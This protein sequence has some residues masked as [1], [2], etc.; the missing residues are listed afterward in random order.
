[1]LNFLPRWFQR[2]KP[3][4]RAPIRDRFPVG[5]GTYGEPAVLQWGVHAALRI[6]SFCS[7]ARNVTII[8]D[9]DHR[10]DWVTTYPFMNFRPSAKGIEGH[11]RLKGEVVIE[12][13]V[14]IGYGATI[15]S[16][17]HIGNGAVVGACSVVTKSVPPYGIVAGNPA[18][19]LRSRFPTD[20]VRLLEHLAWWDWDDA[21]L[22]RAM[23]LLLS[24]DVAALAR[25]A[26]SDLGRNVI[27]PASA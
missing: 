26:A 8:L 15:L 16:G 17:V 19:F 9:G 10:I 25:F 18:K 13:D 23:P 11:P 14:W 3:S 2:R 22:D 24:G 21:A 12:N 4:R 20:T 6:G 7:I 5:R 27:I 1:M